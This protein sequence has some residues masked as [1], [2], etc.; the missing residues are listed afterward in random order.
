MASSPLVEKYDLSTLKGVVSGAAPLGDGLTKR[1]LA[2]MHPT[3]RITQGYG[4]GLIFRLQTRVSQTYTTVPGLT[5]TSPTTHYMPLHLAADNSGSIGVLV[6]HLETRLVDIDGNDVEDG[7]PG[8]LWIKGP[9]V[10]KGYWRNEEATKNT[11]EG[12]WFKTGDIAQRD[13]DGFYL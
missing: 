1:V 6:P 12:D 2:R 9:T 10:M 8:E 11:F 5:E 3:F 4:E 7:Q 13:K